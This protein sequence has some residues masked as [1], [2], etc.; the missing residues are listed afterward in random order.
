MSIKRSYIVVG[1]YCVNFFILN[2]I[3]VHKIK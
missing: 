3:I 1:F 2:E